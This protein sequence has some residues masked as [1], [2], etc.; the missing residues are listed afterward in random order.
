MQLKITSESQFSRYVHFR[1]GLQ[2]N[3]YQR[4]KLML[5]LSAEIH[6]FWQALQHT[7]DTSYFLTMQTVFLISSTYNYTNNGNKQYMIIIIIIIIIRHSTFNF[8]W[9]IK[10]ES[11][12]I[13]KLTTI[14]RMSKIYKIMALEGSSISTRLLQG[15]KSFQ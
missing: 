1:A 8:Q 15:W 14:T 10:F 12:F 3:F 5:L 6:N 9:G 13:N 7:I 2:R 4:W 11:L